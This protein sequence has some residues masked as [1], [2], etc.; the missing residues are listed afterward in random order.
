[1]VS[2]N[3]FDPLSSGH[4]ATFVRSKTKQ[5]VVGFRK[6]GQE[7]RSLASQSLLTDLG[8]PSWRELD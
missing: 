1:M 4:D 7:S 8:A 2:S 3:E 5:G 6:D